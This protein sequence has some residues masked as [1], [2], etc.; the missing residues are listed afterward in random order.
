MK[1]LLPLIFLIGCSQDLNN[2]PALGCVA[3]IVNTA[4]GA[5][6]FFAEKDKSY[7]VKGEG[8]VVP[9]MHAL[10]C[11]NGSCQDIFS[12]IELNKSIQTGEFVA[13]INGQ[14]IVKF[15]AP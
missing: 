9:A 5:C 12:F 13:P 2:D 1:K 6:S 10:L 15:I 7:Y 3:S 14:I 11:Y 8:Q 4:G